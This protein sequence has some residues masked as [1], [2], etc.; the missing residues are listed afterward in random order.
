MKNEP[1]TKIAEILRDASRDPGNFSRSD[2]DELAMLTELEKVRLPKRFIDVVTAT[3]KIF[4]AL[5]SE[6][7]K[8]IDR[9]GRILEVATEFPNQEIN[10][11]DDEALVPTFHLTRHDHDRVMVL[12][13]DM[14]KIIFASAVFDEPHKRRLLN[15]I[16]AIEKQLLQEK[17]IFDIVRGG[18]SDFGETLGKFGVDIKPLTDRMNE[19]VKIVRGATKEYDQLPAPDD[20]KRLPAPDSPTQD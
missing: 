14:R 10:S 18:I 17:G 4:P 11:T 13:S 7:E 15:R 16:A 6:R 2:M 20:V 3:D 8:F 9:L 5:T 19:V 12:C 1:M